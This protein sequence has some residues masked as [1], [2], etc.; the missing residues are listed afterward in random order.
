M[1]VDSTDALFAGVKNPWVIAGIVLL[2]IWTIIWKGMA[3]WKSAQLSHKRWFIFFLIVNTLGIMEI[4]YLRFIVKN[5]SVE[6]LD[7]TEESK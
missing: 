5:Y 4:I 7:Q 2:L 6:T 3:L 1:I